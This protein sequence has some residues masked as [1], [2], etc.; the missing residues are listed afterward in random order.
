MSGSIV[1]NASS[2]EGLPDQLNRL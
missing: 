1:S 2:S